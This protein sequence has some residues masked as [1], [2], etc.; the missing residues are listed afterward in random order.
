[1]NLR[2]LKSRTNYFEAQ[3]V[4]TVKKSPLEQELP[5][6]YQVYGGCKWL[7]IA[8]PEQLRIKEEQVREAFHYIEKYW[9]E[10]PEKTPTFHSIVPS[11]EIYGYRNKVE[12]SWGK[13]ISEKEGIRDDFRFG[14]HAQGQFDRIIDCDFCVLADDEI[15]AIFR[16]MNI[17]SRKSGL[18][19]YD[20]KINIG[21]WRHFVVRKAHFTGEIMLILSVN[22]EFEEYNRKYEGDILIFAGKLMAQFP[23]VVSIYLLKNSGRAD[24]V[25]GEAILMKGKP[26]ITENLLGK[27]F[28]INP[29]S[30]FQT[31]SLGAEKL[32]TVVRDLM[33]TNGGT[34]LDLYA[35]TGTIGILLSDRF[36]HVYSVELVAEASKDGAKNALKN[37]VTNIT[38]INEKTEKF[39]PKFLSE[40]EQE[41]PQK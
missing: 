40:N 28:E 39:L 2:I 9:N 22:H 6:H 36:E 4:E 3:I 23:N 12:F 17:Y 11:P 37:G 21:F 1:M 5:A 34:L 25:T 15:N 20:P 14:F 8:Y 29:K 35:G 41:T 13:Y 31:N 27:S 19:T 18:P 30:F 24:I 38:F 33:K 10:A 16:E 7:P 26:T 32:Y